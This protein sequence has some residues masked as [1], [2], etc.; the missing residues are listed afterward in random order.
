MAGRPPRYKSTEELENKIEE[1]FKSCGPVYAKDKSTGNVIIN[2]KTGNPVII[3]YVHPTVT[4]LALY[5]GFSSRKALFDYKAKKQFS[6]TIMRARARIEEHAEQM[7]YDKNTARGAE[8]NLK[9]NFGWTNEET[10]NIK[11]DKASVDEKA[12]KEALENLGY[13]KDS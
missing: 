10:I 13:K 12:A 2:E 11:T 9:V 6:N 7:L 3:D 5:L 4:G 1:Y 8:F